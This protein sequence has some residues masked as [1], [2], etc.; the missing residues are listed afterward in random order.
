VK[1]CRDIELALSALHD[2]ALTAQ[3]EIA[4]V[5]EHCATCPSCSSFAGALRALDGLPAPVAPAALADRV[6]AAM[7]AEAEKMAQPAGAAVAAVPLQERLTVDAKAPAWLT[8]TR[9]WAITGGV[10]ASAA[11]LVM[12]VVLSQGLDVRSGLDSAARGPAASPPAAES[13]AAGSTSAP[14]AGAPATTAKETAPDYIVF[15]GAVYVGEGN[16]DATGS[17]L[18]TLGVVPTSL[19]LGGSALNLTVFRSGT[20]ALALVLGLPTGSYRRFGPVTRKYGARTYQLQSG[21]AIARFG[22][23]PR[24]VASVPEP[25]RADG[26]PIMQKYGLDSAGVPIFVRI[27]ANPDG[28]FAVAPGTSPDDPAAGNPFWTWWAP[29]RP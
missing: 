2:G 28:G 10:A 19:D 13:G 24:L 1:D 16:I 27:G 6:A 12:A 29:T 23:W 25:T 21:T 11:V 8:R 17:A 26:Y 3:D 14:V 22:E 9:L 4:A 5:R 20:D 15:S 7:S 18:T